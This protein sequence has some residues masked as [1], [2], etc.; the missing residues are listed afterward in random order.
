ML[1]DVAA[2]DDPGG[3]LL[4]HGVG[5]LEDLAVAHA[6]AAAD[7]QRDAGDGHDALVLG[8]VVAGI[9]LDD[10]GAELD[11]LADDADDAIDVSARVIARRALL[12]GERLDHQRHPD[13]VAVGAQPADVLDAL[14]PHLGA[15][16]HVEQVRDD[17][18]G[19]E[20]D[21]L[22][23]GVLD[24]QRPRVGGDLGRVDVRGVGAHDERGL[25]AAGVALEQ[26]GLAGRE[27]DGVGR[28]VDQRRDRGLHVLD[29][30]EEVGLAGEA[31]VDGDVEAAAGG[32]VE[33][34]VQAVGLHAA[35]KPC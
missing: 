31:V 28:G 9:G 14:P 20:P 2:V 23:D 25:V 8:D 10:V 4:E 18:G 15:A 19:V 16:G 12:E 33:E 7:E 13:V 21:G 30:G 32:G 26:V 35:I 24:H 1:D 11:G 6:P 5:A 3:A 27:L 29:A 22:A 17:A 34:S